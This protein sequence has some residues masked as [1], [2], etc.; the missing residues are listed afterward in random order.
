MLSERYAKQLEKSQNLSSNKDDCRLFVQ[1]QSSKG[2]HNSFSPD[3]EIQMSSLNGEAWDDFQNKSIK[4]ALDEILRCKMMAKLDAS[5]QNVQ[6]QYEDWNRYVIL[7]DFNNN[8]INNNSNSN[9]QLFLRKKKILSSQ[10]FP[11]F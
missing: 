8:I 3:V 9:V 5:S 4:T 11:S 10:C 6:S 7:Y 2:V 1:S